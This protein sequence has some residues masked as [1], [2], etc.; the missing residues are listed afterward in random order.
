MQRI[1]YLTAHPDASN[2]ESPYF[3]V[4]PAPALPAST[5]TEQL[6]SVL[7]D[8]SARMFDVSTPLPLLLAHTHAG[9]RGKGRGACCMHCT[10]LR[11]RSGACPQGPSQAV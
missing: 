2:E 8:E 11:A 9:H 6:A 4:D 10:A 3:S 5:P 1:E 7:L